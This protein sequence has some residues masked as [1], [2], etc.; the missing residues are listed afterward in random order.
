[1][2]FVLKSV[3]TGIAALALSTT[4]HAYITNGSFDD[5]LNGWTDSPVGAGVSVVNEG[6][7]NILKIDDPSSVGVE[8]VYQSFY[9]PA[10][11]TEL[12]VSFSYRFDKV[13]EGLVFDDWAQGRLFTLGTGVGDWI[14][15]TELFSTTT[16][17]NGWVTFNGVYDISGILNFNPNAR[18]GFGLSEAWGGIFSDWTD[19]ALYLDDIVI[20]DANAVAVPEPGSLAL[21]GLGMI[22]LG[23]ARRRRD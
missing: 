16:D 2:N 3:G 8:W 22:G 1:M 9:V 14:V 17:S 10:G 12:S 21:L 4:A 20:G 15:G 18:I 7:N 6:G 5:G 13:G 23:I 19:S 11:V